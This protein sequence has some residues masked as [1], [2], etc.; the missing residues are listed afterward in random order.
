M[1]KLRIL[2]SVRVALIIFIRL[3]NA[4]FH[5]ELYFDIYALNLQFSHLHYKDSCIKYS[6]IQ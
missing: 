1:S 2:L 6:K 3:K 4:Q 5:I